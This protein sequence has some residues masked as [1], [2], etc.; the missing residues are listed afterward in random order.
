M[1]E[2]CKR[3]WL[4]GLTWIKGTVLRCS[5]YGKL[6]L[7]KVSCRVRRNADLQSGLIARKS[8]ARATFK[9]TGISRC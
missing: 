1:C 6:C 8:G 4:F 3:S 2:G 9:D 7:V 5:E